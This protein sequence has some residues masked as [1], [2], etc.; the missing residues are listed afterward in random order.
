M[1][2]DWMLLALLFALGA[3]VFIASLRTAEALA[4][5]RSQHERQAAELAR[6]IRSGDHR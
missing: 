4:H 1:I 6:H 3:L 5:L 2:A